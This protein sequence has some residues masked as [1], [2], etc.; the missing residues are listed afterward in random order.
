M[1]ISEILGKIGFDWQVALANLFNFLIIFFILKK[2]AFGPIGKLI[3]ERQDKINEGIENAT[4]NADLLDSTQKEKDEILV[5]ARIESNKIIQETKKDLEVKRT[6]LL[7]QAK[8]EAKSIIDNTKQAIEIE[9]NKMLDEAKK[10]IVSLA[11]QATE[12]LM[13]NKEAEYTK[14]KVG[15]LK[16]I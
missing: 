8:L 14:N 6:E 5:S 12:K 11:M 7:D 13:N 3:K 2:Y 16:S 4:K 10:E 1:D 15:E 9:K